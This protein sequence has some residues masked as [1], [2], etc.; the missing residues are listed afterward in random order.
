MKT[1][2]FLLFT[3]LF[4][5]CGSP[6]DSVKGNG[7]LA[8]VVIMNVG[9]PH[10]VARDAIVTNLGGSIVSR[11]RSDSLGRATVPLPAGRYSWGLADS[12]AEMRPIIILPGALTRDTTVICPMCM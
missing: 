8:A 1:S 9:P 11:F 12:G 10:G 6:S 7:T 5:A 2:A 4:A 3:L